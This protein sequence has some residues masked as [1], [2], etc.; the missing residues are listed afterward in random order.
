M[1]SAEIDADEPEI[2]DA[3]IEINAFEIE[4]LGGEIEDDP[5]MKIEATGEDLVDHDPQPVTPDES[6]S[7]G[8][9]THTAPASGHSDPPAQ[10]AVG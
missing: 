8:S 6:I 4:D 9:G 2:I 5:D 10:Q 1:E 3:D 7:P